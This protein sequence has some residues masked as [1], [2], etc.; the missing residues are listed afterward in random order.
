VLCVFAMCVCYACAMCDMCAMCVYYMC[1]LCVC[2]CVVISF[3]KEL[4][5]F[6][7]LYE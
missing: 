3:V 7:I 6:W 4:M 5:Y 1:L 2:V